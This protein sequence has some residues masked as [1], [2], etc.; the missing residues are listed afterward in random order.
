[1]SGFLGMLHTDPR[2]GCISKALFES[3][4][5]AAY[6][7]K[8][9]PLTLHRYWSLLTFQSVQEQA[10]VNFLRDHL[11]RAQPRRGGQPFSGTRVECVARLCP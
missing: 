9:A 10:R 7:A 2:L 5:R 4:L 8:D 6:L 3:K 11:Q 1:M